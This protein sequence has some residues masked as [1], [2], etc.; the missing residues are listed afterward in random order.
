MATPYSELASAG[1]G[2]L[3]FNLFNRPNVSQINPV[4]GSGLTPIP[5]C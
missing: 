3:L 5:V 4:F 2:Y 1:A